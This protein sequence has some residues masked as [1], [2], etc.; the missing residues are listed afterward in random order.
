MK[1]KVEDGKLVYVKST[2][3][4]NRIRKLYRVNPKKDHEREVE[5]GESE[6]DEGTFQKS[7]QSHHGGADH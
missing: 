7:N 2:G 1:I 3:A 4:R 5:M 6:E